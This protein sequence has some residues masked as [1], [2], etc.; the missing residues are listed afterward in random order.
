MFPAGGAALDFPGI[1]EAP[2]DA[3]WV[4]R[5]VSA[6]VNADRADRRGAVRRRGGR[7]PA[8]RLHGHPD[9]IDPG[10]APHGAAATDCL[11]GRRDISVGM[12]DAMLDKVRKLLAK[13]EDPACTPAEA[14]AFNTK[15][16]ELIAKY[17][18]DRALLAE[19]DPTSDVVGDRVIDLLAPYAT[20]QMRAA[21][22]GSRPRCAASRCSA[23][24]PC[25]SS[26]GRRRKD[27]S[28]HLFGFASD[29]DRV[30][31]LFTSLLVQ[32]S[33]SLAVQTAPAWENVAA[34]RRSWLAGFTYAVVA[35]LRAA[36][37]R[38]AEPAMPSPRLSTTVGRSVA[39]V[40][41][42]RG[43]HVEQRVAEVYPRLRFAGPRRLAGSGRRQGYAAG[44]RADLG[45]TKIAA[46][47]AGSGEFVEEPVERDPLGIDHRAGSRP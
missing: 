40:L 28:M 8:A 9:R 18:V 11:S 19:S 23:N 38:A 2:Y 6:Y 24:S 33:Q 25:G 43:S 47:S 30:E 29:L 16:A 20:R 34:Y 22:P 35:R 3:R 12:S 14:E 44:Q 37:A 26:R 1:D 10:D 41:A 13:A 31:L 27:F 5:F 45:G 32:A 42:D 36:E 7:R 4:A 15:A 46:R 21:R 39:L 17:G